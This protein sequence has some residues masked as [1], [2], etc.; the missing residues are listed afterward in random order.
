MFKV[1]R[2]ALVGQA[3]KLAE[4]TSVDAVNPFRHFF[5]GRGVSGQFSHSIDE[6]PA[7]V[8]CTVG[9]D[10]S[11]QEV[12]YDLLELAQVLVDIGVVDVIVV[13]IN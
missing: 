1:G 9:L 10:L 6:C 2:G 11:V 5:R 13:H 8:H 7:D 4:R 3:R 12:L